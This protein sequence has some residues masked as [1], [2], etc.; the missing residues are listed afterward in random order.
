MINKIDS[1]SSEFNL[2]GSFTNA[3]MRFASDER[4][5][6]VY[7]IIIINSISDIQELLNTHAAASHCKA[8]L[9][10]L[11]LPQPIQ[12]L[13]HAYGPLIQRQRAQ[14]GH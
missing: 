6:E 12:T 8:S 11:P 3:P 5:F 7:S 9:F 4:D 10:K 14:T 13:S 1:T 2:D